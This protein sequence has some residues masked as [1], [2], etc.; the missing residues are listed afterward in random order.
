MKKLIFYSAIISLGMIY[1]CA[2]PEGKKA[3]IGEADTI[4]AN[5]EGADKFIIDT[6]KA[7]VEWKGFKPTGQHNGT[8]AIKS[9]TL[10]MKENTPVGGNF[11]LD[12]QSVKV[13]DIEDPEYNGKLKGHLRSADFFDVDTHPE[14]TFVITQI[15][16][17]KESNSTYNLTGNLTIKGITKS[18]GFVANVKTEGENFNASTPEFTINRTEYDI[19]FKSKK[20]FTDLQNDFI[21]DEIALV[22]NLSGVKSL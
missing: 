19:R 22:I 1:S 15:V 10:F 6:A 7:M 12:M 2:G 5:T 13:L 20:F 8:L 3:N 18:V 21:N 4:I 14:A 17:S 16:R 9:G 11:V